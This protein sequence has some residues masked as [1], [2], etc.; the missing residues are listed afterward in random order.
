MRRL[1]SVWLPDWPVTAWSR[2]AGRQ[3][4]PEDQAFALID[5]GVHGL[6]L[7]AL[8]KRARTLGLYRGQAHADACAAVPDLTSAPAELEADLADLK[9]LALW[10]ERFSPAVATDVAVPALEGLTL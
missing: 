9:R 8:N 2:R 1:V 4:P 6:T 3:Q 10:A 7:H 5:K